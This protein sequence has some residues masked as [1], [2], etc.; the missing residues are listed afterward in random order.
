MLTS[1][2]CTEFVNELSTKSPVPGGGSA[3]AL[4]AALAAALGSMVASL[5]V[6]KKKYAAVEPEI[7][8]FQAACQELMRESL[9]LAEKDAEAFV[10]LTRAWSMPKGTNEERSARDEAIERALKDAAA[11]PLAVMEATC[12]IIDLASQLAVKGS[13]IAVS[14]AGVSAALARAALQ[15]AAFNVFI[16]TKSMKDRVAADE[17]NSRADALLHRGIPA[18][19]A[20]CDRVTILLR[21]E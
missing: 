16:N 1:M 18:A 6:G 11:A 5:T 17:L 14:D 2:S 10:P 21:P 9:N 13:R 19:D 3:S 4:T 12:R 8:E 15:G 20:L 7:R